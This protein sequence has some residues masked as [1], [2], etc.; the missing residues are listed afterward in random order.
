MTPTKVSKATQLEGALGGGQSSKTQGTTKNSSNYTY[1][2]KNGTM[3]APLPVEESGRATMVEDTTNEC[4]TVAPIPVED[5]GR[6]EKVEETTNDCTMV[7]QRRNDECITVAPLPD[8]D[9][10]RIKMMENTDNKCTM[11]APYQDGGGVGGGPPHG[12]CTEGGAGDNYKGTTKN[13]LHYNEF[14]D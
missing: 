11:V 5:C 10:G 3:V 12:E 6:P 2:F 7:A 1:E 4:T 13:D 8:V 14:E 9:C